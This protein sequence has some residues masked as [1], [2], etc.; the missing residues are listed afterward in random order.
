M[1]SKI[2]RGFSGAP[3]NSA[4]LPAK[5]FQRPER[6]AAL[7]KTVSR[8]IPNTKQRWTNRRKKNYNLTYCSDKETDSFHVHCVRINNVGSKH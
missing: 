6:V 7:R 8:F 3:L 5:V 1:F 2:F 4:R